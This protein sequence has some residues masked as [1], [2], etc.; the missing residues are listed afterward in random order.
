M[1]LFEWDEEKNDISKE[2]YKSGKESVLWL[3]KI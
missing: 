3:G 1:M 2:G